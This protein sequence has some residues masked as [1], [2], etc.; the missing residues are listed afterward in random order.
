[1]RHLTLINKGN[2]CYFAFFVT[3][4]PSLGEASPGFMIQE[5]GDTVDLFCDA[6]GT[7]EPTLRWFK[8]KQPLKPSDRVSI[9]GNRITVKKL[10]PSDGGAYMCTYKNIVGEVSHVTKLVIAGG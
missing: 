8:D 3:A 7:P 5:E 1:M 10:V 4:P 9:H 6:T 2:N